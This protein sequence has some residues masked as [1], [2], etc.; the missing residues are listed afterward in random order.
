MDDKTDMLCEESKYPPE[1]GLR[2]SEVEV[3]EVRAS[4][5][6]ALQIRQCG[7]EEW[8][9]TFFPHDPE[10]PGELAALMGVTRAGHYVV[11]RLPDSPKWVAVWER[12]E[13]A[14]APY[15]CSACSTPLVEG[16]LGGR[17]PICKRSLA[18]TATPWPGGDE[19]AHN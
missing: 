5:R 17:C 14:G 12:P 13:H 11:D 18:S 15:M 3:R 8:G 2:V 6:P 1:E 7:A 19:A 16:H 9:M 10:T 4:H